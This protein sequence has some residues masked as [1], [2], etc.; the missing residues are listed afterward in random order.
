MVL[1]LNERS[2]MMKH[3]QKWQSLAV[4]GTIFTMSLVGCNE[5]QVEDNKEVIVTPPTVTVTEESI[6]NNAYESYD[7]ITD[8]GVVINEPTEEELNQLGTVEEYEYDKNA[9]ES[10]L[11]IPKYNGTKITVNTVEYT[12]ERYITKDVLYSVEST[13]EGYGLLIKANRPEG[14]AQIGVY[15]TYKE[16]YVEHIIEADNG[17][18]GESS[19]EFLKIDPENT[20][21]IEEDII[22]PEANASTYLEGLTRYNAYEVDMDQDGKME[23][24]EVYCQSGMDENGRYLLDDGQDWALI[25]RKG[26]EIYPLFE[27]S[28]IQ[29]GGLEY[30]V[31]EDCDNYNRKHIIIYYNTGA[32]IMYYDCTYD[33]ESGYIRRDNL[34]EASNISKLNEWSYKN[35]E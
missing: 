24:I 11:I 33:E 19:K 21:K 18:D 10:I 29:L 25:L 9:T 14:M 7:N 5:A 20:N 17:K 27:K 35:C 30:M 15:V 12:G 26:D 34:Y 31:Y 3:I 1:S 28:F 16:K 22:K 23:T 6:Y 2:E 4:I 13:P 32:A 8:F